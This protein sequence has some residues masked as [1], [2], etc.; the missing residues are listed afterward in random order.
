[1]RTEQRTEVILTTEYRKRHQ[2]RAV[3]G[4]SWNPSARAWVLDHPTPR[5][6]AVALQVFPELAS[7]YP[8]LAEL[9]D[10]AASNVRPFDNATPYGVEIGAP[11]VRAQLASEGKS[12][13][14]FQSVDLGYVAAVLEAHGGAYIGWSRGLGKT[15]GTFALMDE[16]R[17]RR[18][19]IV[20]PNTAK[21]SVWR[22]ELAIRLPGVE[23]WVLPNAKAKRE[24]MVQDVRRR[25]RDA[26]PL[27]L[28]VHYE[29]LALIAGKA[30][31]EKG[32]TVL[33]DGW[34][35]LGEWDLVVLDEGHRIKNSRSL[36]SRAAKKIPAKRRLILSGSIIENEVEE[37]FSPLQFLFPR[38]Y[39]SKW[40]DW[41]D[42]YIEYARGDF[43]QISLGVKP[44]RIEDLRRELGVFMVVRRKEDELDLPEKTEQTLL[45]DLSPRQRKAYDELRD[46]F[47]TMLD[48]GTIVKAA[49]GLAQLTRLRQVA[50]G[51]DLF[52]D[53]QDSTKIDLALELLLDNEEPAVVFS[54]Y[55]SA[56]HAMAEAL[57]RAGVEPFV[58]TGDVPQ[59]QRSEMIS[60]FQGGE[61][62]V[63]IGTLSTLG[64]SVNLQ[65]ASQGIFLDRAWNPAL[66]AQATDRIY[67]IGQRRPVTITHIVARDTVDE[68]RV[69]PVL[70]QKEA[71]RAAV[72]GA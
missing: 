19:L 64:E 28:I 47:L 7:R 40:R 23:T 66:N 67:R 59:A 70:A 24:R 53:V 33:G 6:A 20:A 43:G 32:R 52:G 42:R 15:I 36:M 1:M 63:F 72:L 5:S 16:L 38:V 41:N 61:G 71:L 8:E 10:S 37:L 14:T 48:D 62:R 45:V 46:T 69:Q 2:A 26:P 22:D 27:A 9:R 31:N 39:R 44:D 34:K 49:D 56:C 25:S 58:V 54:W 11:G 13:Y 30:K 57:R 17:T 29:A 12:L 60:S 21:D 35:A 4:A 65:R 51:L 18:T 50:T 68:L 3:P 55:K